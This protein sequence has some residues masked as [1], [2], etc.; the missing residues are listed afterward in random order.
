MP[1]QDMNPWAVI[2]PNDPLMQ[3]MYAAQLPQ[4]M[5]MQMPPQLTQAELPLNSVKQKTT[6]R[7]TEVAPLSKSE[8]DDLVSRLNDKGIE[9]MKLQ[10]EGVADLE[11]LRNSLLGQDN[12]QTNLSPLMALV[13]S[14]STSGKANNVAS[15]Q[16]PTGAADAQNRIAQLQGAIQ[17]AKEGLSGN[18]IELLK[19][20]LGIAAQR[21]AADERAEERKYRSDSLKLTKDTLHQDKMDKEIQRQ[22]EAFAKSDEAN[23]LKG[24]KNFA[25]ALDKY[26]AAVRANGV[27]PVGKNA[28]VLNNAYSDLKVAFKEIEDLGALAGPDLGILASQVG[29]SEGIGDYLRTLA[30]GGTEG[31]LSQ[32]REAKKKAGARFGET[33]DILK[34]TFPAIG[35]EQIKVYQKAFNTTSA[36]GNKTAAPDKMAEA[37]KWLE[38]NPDHPKAAA[39]RKALGN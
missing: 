7:N 3:Q 13:D 10:S 18:E 9:S 26:E 15:Y 1:R 14:W 21:E 8:Y 22:R 5:P 38:A 11:F 12:V 35:E 33:T 31:V 20:Q 36:S 39:V 32:V 37:K 27:N 34:S 28:A 23:I 19:S 4:Q 25:S 24:T 29:G 16:Q 30:R 2:D 6:S 17:K